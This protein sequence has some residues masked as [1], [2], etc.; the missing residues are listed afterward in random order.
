MDGTAERD[1]RFDDLASI[2]GSDRDV[3]RML[4]TDPD[5]ASIVLRGGF[6]MADFRSGLHVHGTDA[7]EQRDGGTEIM[8]PPQL[9]VSIV[10]AGSFT[11]ELGD[12]V[13]SVPAATDPRA[14][15]WSVTRPTRLCRHFSAGQHVR[16]VN[17]S[18]GPE[19]LDDFLGD[20]DGDWT[21]VGRFA[22]RH[23][24]M[25]DWAPS[26]ES[27]SAAEALLAC[28]ARDNVLNRISLEICALTILRDAFTTLDPGSDRPAV[29]DG[30]D[31]VQAHAIRRYVAS[32]LLD[33][34]TLGEIAAAVGMSVSKMQRVFKRTF[35]ITIVEHVRQSRLALAHRAIALEG[36]SIQQAAHL[37]GYSSAANFATAFKRQFGRSPSEVRRANRQPGRP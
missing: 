37:A 26:R 3:Y 22:A 32:R 4:D 31:P 12:R 17:I 16:K 25:T 7:V 27:V 30:A 29:A 2:L 6:F 8:L 35:G 10:L 28:L 24:A 33:A 15:M 1:L 19:W 21:A 36:R 23:L 5:D 11:A 14:K 9:S 13:L 18:V 34:C 20:G